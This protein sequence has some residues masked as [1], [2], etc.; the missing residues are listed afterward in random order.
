M[1]DTLSKLITIFLGGGLGSC[2][3]WWLSGLVQDLSDRTAL[4][5]FPLGTFA[6]NGLG[7]LFFGLVFGYLESRVGLSRELRIFALTGF[8]GAFTTFSTFAFE[9]ASLVSSGRTMAALANILGQVLLGLTL[10]F[11][12]LALGRAA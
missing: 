3:R 2:C 8:M 7:C 11:L 9:S 12:G 6:V 5:T 10:T 4:A 1:H